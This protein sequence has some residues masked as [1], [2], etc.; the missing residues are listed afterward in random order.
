MLVL[1][2]KFTIF[3]NV[4]FFLEGGVPEELWALFLEVKMSFTTK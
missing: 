1:S 4:H 3:K 2:N